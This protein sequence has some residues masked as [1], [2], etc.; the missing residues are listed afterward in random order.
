[1]TTLTA[2]GTIDGLPNSGIEDTLRALVEIGMRHFFEL[3]PE[4]QS[5]V[6]LRII[7]WDGVFRDPTPE[8]E[9]FSKLWME[10]IRRAKRLRTVQNQHTETT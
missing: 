8:D 9:C 4:E 7:T 6:L 3:S 10:E 1:M 5:K 2:D